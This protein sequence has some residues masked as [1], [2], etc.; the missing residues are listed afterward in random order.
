[1]SPQLNVSVW[2][3]AEGYRVKA[4]LDWD[5]PLLNFQSPEPGTHHPWL[6]LL[7][8]TPHGCRVSR[9][10]LNP[11][12]CIFPGEEKPELGQVEHL[13]T[14]LPKLSQASTSCAAACSVPDTRKAM[15]TKQGF[16]RPKLTSGSASQ[17]LGT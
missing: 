15:R 1:M 7:W 16:L 12:H 6:Q 4:H 8:Q 5:L 13:T 3:R 9:L 14:F 11:A 10:S 2:L 17:Y